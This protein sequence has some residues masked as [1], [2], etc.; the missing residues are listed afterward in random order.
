[1]ERQAALRRFLT[2]MPERLSPAGGDLRM[3]AVLFRIDAA[4]GRAT[5]VE[6]LALPFARDAG[7]EARRLSGKEPAEATRAAAR[8]R[9]AE[10]REAGVVPGLA[11]VSVGEDPASQ[12]YLER[13]SRA[14]AEVG[15]E[16]RRIALPAGVA[17]EAVVDRVR[18][19]GVDPQVHGI[20][21]QLPLAPPAEAQAVFESV[22]PDKDVDGFHPVNAGRLAAGLP[23]FVPATPRGIL[24]LLRYYEVPLAGRHAVVLGRS[25]IVG[26]PMATL[27]STRGVDMT[28]TIGHS[29]SGPGLRDL[30]READLLVV[31]IG[32]AGSVTA[33]WVK[34]GA[35]VVDVGMH[36]VPAPDGTRLVGDVDLEGVSRVASA[37][38]PV[39]GGVGPMTVAMVVANTVLAAERQLAGVKV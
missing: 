9:V 5:S 23:G 18:A 15:I 29:A 10:L 31:A 1:M 19:L 36:R 22:P 20:L 4:T 6:R 26:R 32:R 8:R 7:T 12:I 21:V 13:K 37:L 11:L 25:N 28:V 3:N 17:T 14:C 39:P 35:V 24:E 38:T 16:A 34:P 2:L 27:L 33:D 30:A